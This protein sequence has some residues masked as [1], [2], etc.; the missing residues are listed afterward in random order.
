MHLSLSQLAVTVFLTAAAV[1]AQRRAPPQPTFGGFSPLLDGGGE[2]ILS[3]P[4]EEVRRGGNDRNP[5]PRSEETGRRAGGNRNPPLEGG[6]GRGGNRKPLRF[7]ASDEQV[8]RENFIESA[9]APRPPG[10][11]R[12]GSGAR[13]GL[14]NNGAGS[15]GARP[16]SRSQN[17]SSRKQNGSSRKQNGSSRLQ[18]G[19]SRPQNGS[20]RPQNGSSRPQNGSS[21]P[22]NGS[23]GRNRGSI[24]QNSDSRSRPFRFDPEEDLPSGPNRGAFFD[25]DEDPLPSGPTRSPSFSESKELPLPAG[26]TRNA[27]LPAGPTR[28]PGQGKRPSAG[29]GTVAP[30]VPQAV[31]D[32]LP[33]IT[34]PR[35][36]STATPRANVNFRLPPPASRHEFEPEFQL[37]RRNSLVSAHLDILDQTQR[38]VKMDPNQEQF[39]KAPTLNAGALPLAAASSLPLNRFPPFNDP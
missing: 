14:R 13:P 16:S 33:F 19:S 15:Q 26:P 21:R 18:N 36:R 11:S 20:N 4:L 3:A 24:R 37:P 32:R 5:P 12:F 28:R 25:E 1:G 27:P 7:P 30:T 23:S 2:D 17:G 34:T 29:R 22:Q 9:P 6:G 39:I 31:F 8:R 35:P 10:G 38:F